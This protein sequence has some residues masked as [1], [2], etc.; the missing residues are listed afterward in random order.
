M[1]EVKTVAKKRNLTFSFMYFLGIL[2]VI[3]AHTKISINILN[4][5]FPYESFFMPMFFFA[6]G[7]FYKHRPLKKGIIRKA[8]NLFLRY[9]VWSL[10]IFLVAILIDKVCG[11]QWSVAPN[12]RNLLSTF[13]FGPLVNLNDASW[14]V[15]TLFWVEIFYMFFDHLARNRS[16]TF[17]LFSTIIIT[18]SGLVALIFA[19]NQ[20]GFDDGDFA[21]FLCRFFFYLVFYNFGYIFHKYLEEKINSIKHANLIVPVI[22]VF[23]N[24]I[25]ISIFGLDKLQFVTTMFMSS[26]QS[27]ILPF[28]TS[29]TGILFYYFISKMLAK[30]IGENKYVEY[31][32]RN[33]FIILETHMI[34]LQL[35]NIIRLI[36]HRV[37]PSHFNEIADSRAVLTPWGGANLDSTALAF[38]C[39]LFFSL[40]VVWGLEKIR[41]KFAMFWNRLKARIFCRRNRI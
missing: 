11:T 36:I 17:D 26:F 19:I 21:C 35:P 8:K 15:V 20:I 10:A 6:S 40:F 18:W 13:Y 24:L 7:Y 22:C 30:Y 9:L 34:G 38:F 12:R 28:I 16:R 41:P 25:L 29:V 23:I 3:D 1:S 37:S 31:I 39:A 33:T 27:V 14:F 32:S 2:M 4:N 5:I